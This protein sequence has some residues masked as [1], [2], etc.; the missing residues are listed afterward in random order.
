[1]GAYDIIKVYGGE[2]NVYTKESEGTE[3]IIQLPV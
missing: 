2:L 1:L 3:F